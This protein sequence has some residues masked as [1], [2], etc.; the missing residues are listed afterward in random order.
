[1]FYSKCSKSIYFFQKLFRK[2]TRCLQEFNHIFLAFCA[3]KASGYPTR[4]ILV[5]K[6]CLPIEGAKHLKVSWQI[7]LRSIKQIGGF[8]GWSVFFL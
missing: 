1:M 6:G 7:V 4:T 3:L 2:R 8:E 5:N